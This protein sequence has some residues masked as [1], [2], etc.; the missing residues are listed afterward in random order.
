MV[1]NGTPVGV[2]PTSDLDDDDCDVYAT[3]STVV[4]ASPA[5]TVAVDRTTL[6]EANR[7]SHEGGV[8]RVS[9]IHSRGTGALVAVVAV[10][11]EVRED[12]SVTQPLTF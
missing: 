12:F 2:I 7:V 1:R 10:G 9:R 6:R 4:Y 3:A 11:P 8:P 5:A